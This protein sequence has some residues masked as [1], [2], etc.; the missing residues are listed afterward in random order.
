MLRWEVILLGLKGIIDRDAQCR[1]FCIDQSCLPNLQKDQ[2]KEKQNKLNDTNKKSSKDHEEFVLRFIIGQ[3][4]SMAM[5]TKGTLLKAMLRRL[6]CCEMW[7][8]FL[9]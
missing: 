6:I 9:S 3:R 2:T 7:R 8:S 5:R 4:L 1:N